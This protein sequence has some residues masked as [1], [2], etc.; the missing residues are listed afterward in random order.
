MYIYSTYIYIY[1]YIY[2]LRFG[3]GRQPPDKAAALRGN[4]GA[5]DP[6]RECAL[7]ELAPGMDLLGGAVGGAADTF[8]MAG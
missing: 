1:I 2:M 3:G 8:I 5:T 7:G 4:I 6:A